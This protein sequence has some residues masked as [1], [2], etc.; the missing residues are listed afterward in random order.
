MDL[1]IKLKPSRLYIL[2]ILVSAMAGLSG[3][4][5][6]G[7][8]LGFYLA[9][10]TVWLIGFYWALQSWLQ[11]PTAIHLRESALEIEVSGCRY[12]ETSARVLPFLLC[13]PRSDSAPSMLVWCDSVE[14]S[15]WRRLRMWLKI[16]SV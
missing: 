7:A 14:D 15:E 12:L 2:S 9:F 11:S 6:V 10:L 16:H 4:V 5:L 3:I 13:F 1:L 8:P